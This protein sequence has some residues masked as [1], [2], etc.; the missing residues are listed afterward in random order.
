[1][2]STCPSDDEVTYAMSTRFVRSRVEIA[3]VVKS[4][5]RS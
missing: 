1:V 2:I 3:A 5:A 4:N